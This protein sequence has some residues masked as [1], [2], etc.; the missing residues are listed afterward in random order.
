MASMSLYPPIVAAA[1]PAFIFNQPARIYFTLSNY[2]S[3]Q[4][5]GR[6]QLVVR[7]Q[8]TNRNALNKS[9]WTN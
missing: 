4:E 6:I 7:Y 5:V 1:M 2:N 9:L 8:T 3:I